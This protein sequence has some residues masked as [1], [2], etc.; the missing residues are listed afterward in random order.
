MGRG[1][2]NP[3]INAVMK[4]IVYLNGRYTGRGEAKISPEDR[5][6]NFADGVY[7]VIKFYAG[8]P[9]RYKDHIDRLK[10]S[11]SAVRIE[12]DKLDEFAEICRELLYRNHLATTDAGAYIQITRGEHARVHHFPEN[13]QPTVYVFVF[14]FPSFMKSLKTG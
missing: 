6:F 14:P 10:Y 7:E 4:E 12:Y 1:D 11:L 2:T 3:Q 9:F 8:R 13:L 5:G